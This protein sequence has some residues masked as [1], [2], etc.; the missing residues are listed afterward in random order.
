[1]ATTYIL[2][3]GTPY[4]RTRTEKG[5]TADFIF[6]RDGLDWSEG[7]TFYYWGISGET[8]QRY[9]VDNNLSFSFTDD[10]RIKWEA[11]RYSGN[12]DPSSGYTENFYISSGQTPQLC[13]TNLHKCFNVTIVFDRYKRYEDCDLENSGGKNDLL[14]WKI[15]DYVDTEVTAVTSTQHMVYET[16]IESLSKKWAS[17]RE[18]RLG[19][20]KIY[21]NGRPI[22][23]LENWE[24]IIPTQRGSENNLIQS[25]GGGT[26]GYLSIHTG[27]TQFIIEEVSYL[28]QPLDFLHVRHNFLTRLNNYDF[29]ICGDDCIDYPT[30]INTNEIGL[31]TEFGENILTEDN[32]L[33]L[34]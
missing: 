24:E 23:K 4:I 30:G 25:W 9:F 18:R 10:G 27:E 3:S 32:Y 29:F 12:C 20:L 17:E 28:E 19:I 15:Y 1:M 26:D 13:T 11:Y 8:N 5:W 33:T 2:E 31:L 7:S 16:E 34:Y 21:L 22:Y 6:N 14:G